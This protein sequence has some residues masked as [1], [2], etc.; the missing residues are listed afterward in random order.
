MINV[1]E[2]RFF[3]MIAMSFRKAYNYYL[4]NNPSNGL[5]SGQS[6]MVKEYRYLGR[7]Q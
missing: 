3:L 2:S 1:I 5:D 6:R 7:K 4:N